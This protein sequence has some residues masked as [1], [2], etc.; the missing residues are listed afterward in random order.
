[1]KRNNFHH[2]R[3][4]LFSELKHVARNRVSGCDTIDRTVLQRK[5]AHQDVASVARRVTGTIVALSVFS[6]PIR[7]NNLLSTF[8]RF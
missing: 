6:T 7:D 2:L 8:L 4:S 1:M 3:Y 5:Q